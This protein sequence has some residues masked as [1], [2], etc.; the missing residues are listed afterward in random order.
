MYI[1]Y[2]QWHITTWKDGHH[3]SLEN[4]KLKQKWE[5][6]T[7]LVWPGM[8][9]IQR[10][11]IPNT[12]E[13]VRQQELLHYSYH[14]IQQWHSLLFTQMSWKLTSNKIWHREIYG[15]FI[16]NYQILKATKMSF[17][18]WMD[19]LVAQTMELTSTSPKKK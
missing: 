17:S 13:N 11:T 2:I 18:K 3:I 10:A 5:T 12:G 7:H 9:Q 1:W 19:K 15:S 4:C 16:H 6:T 14:I 8:T